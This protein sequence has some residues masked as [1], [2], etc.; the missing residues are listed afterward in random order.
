MLTTWH[1]V[2]KYRMNQL[3]PFGRDRGGARLDGAEVREDEEDGPAPH[4]RRDAARALGEHRDLLDRAAARAEEPHREV[5][6]PAGA[7]RGGR[8][9]QREGRVPAAARAQ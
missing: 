1:S 7:L 9:G 3:G 2:V 8:L 6:E 4:E 5:P